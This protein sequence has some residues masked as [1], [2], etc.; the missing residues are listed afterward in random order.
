MLLAIVRV[1]IAIRNIRRKEKNFVIWG[2]DAMYHDANWRIDHVTNSAIGKKI[3][4]YWSSLR[5][6]GILKFIM[7]FH[8]Q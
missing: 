6:R 3:M 2:S 1:S 4:E 5:L 8:S 7:N